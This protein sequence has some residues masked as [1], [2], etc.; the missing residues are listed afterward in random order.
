MGPVRVKESECPLPGES[1]SLLNKCEELE[2]DLQ[3]GI[4]NYAVKD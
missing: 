4:K 1:A 2:V 3:F